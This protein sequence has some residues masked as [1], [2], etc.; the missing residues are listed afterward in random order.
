MR[1]AGQGAEGS[2]AENTRPPAPPSSLCLSVCL[3]V[4]IPGASTPR[5]AAPRRACA[6]SSYSMF[7]SSTQ[8]LTL[9][10]ILSDVLNTHTRHH[11]SF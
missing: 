4:V 10:I 1:P 3:F 9:Y 5:P 8:S 7:T 6:H 11:S 2:R